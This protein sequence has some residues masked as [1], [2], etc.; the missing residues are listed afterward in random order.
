MAIKKRDARRFCYL[1]SYY[2]TFPISQVL[3]SPCTLIKYI[4]AHAQQWQA[5][6]CHKRKVGVV[7]G[8]THI[9]STTQPP[10]YISGTAS[11]PCP[12][13]QLCAEYLLCRSVMLLMVSNSEEAWQI[14]GIAC[15][16]LC[17]IW[18]YQSLKW[19]PDDFVFFTTL[20]G[21][22]FVPYLHSNVDRKYLKVFS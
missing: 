6:Y 16:H 13:L 8:A 11:L 7:K 10:S 1:F 21:T 12:L 20:D 3:Q 9:F 17:R 19:G 22:V 14:F 2:A 18:I 5:H 15:H 4:I